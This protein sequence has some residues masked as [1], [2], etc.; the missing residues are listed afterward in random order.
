MIEF[1]IMGEDYSLSFSSDYADSNYGSPLH[2][3]EG[4]YEILYL[5]EGNPH[6]WVEGTSYSVVKGDIVIARQDEMHRMIHMESSLYKRLVV[7]VGVEFFKKAGHLEYARFFEDR[8]VGVGNHFSSDKA[9]EEIVARI[10]KYGQMGEELLVRGALWE[11]I[12]TLNRESDNSLSESRGLAQDIVLYINEN[13]TLPLSLEKIAERF[14]IS[15]YHLC[16]IFKE[17]LG[18]TVAR[19]IIHKRILMVKEL[20]A[21]GKNITEACMAS[22]FGDYSSFYV[23][24]KKE[25]GRSPA[26]DLK[27]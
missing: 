27:K 5:D 22:G 8:P 10:I 15:K 21:S 16:R 13:I 9:F 26:C 23:A 24:Y 20:C 14:Y 18:L 7:N 3:H 1:E 11:L 2:I 25:T 6:F 17:K 19:Y 4:M 12:W